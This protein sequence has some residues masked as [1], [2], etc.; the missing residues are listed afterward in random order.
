VPLNALGH[1]TTCF[2]SVSNLRRRG[3][4]IQG[5][6][7]LAENSTP[8]IPMAKVIAH[9]L[10]ILGRHGMQA[11]RDGAMLDMVRTGK[12]APAKLVGKKINLQQSIAALMNLDKFEVAGVTV[13]ADF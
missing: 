4:Q 6:L 2:N 5:G 11:H 1:P 7:M 3:K 9:E 13:I 10:E 8:A 12:L